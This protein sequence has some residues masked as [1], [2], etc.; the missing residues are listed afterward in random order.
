VYK[1]LVAFDDFLVDRTGYRVGF[2]Y[3]LIRADDDSQRLSLAVAWRHEWIDI[4]DIDD[5]A[6]P[7]AFLF[8][9]EQELRSVA[10]RLNH[11]LSDDIRNPE[12][13]W[14]ANIGYEYGGAALGGQLDFWKLSGGARYG[15]VLWR[16]R[17]GH[18][19]RFR[20]DAR[21]GLASKLDDTPEVPPY[22]RYYLGGNSFRGFANRGVGP[23]FGDS[24]TGGEWFFV[25]QSEFEVPVVRGTLAVVGFVDWGTL[26][27]SIDSDDAFRL[28]ASVGIGLRLV[29][30]II[31]NQPLAFDFGFPILSEDEDEK[32]VVSFSLGRDF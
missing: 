22:E 25:H 17:D 28:R 9:K 2:D 5:D 24:S 7:G 26:A 3:P 18:A 1:R 8:R 10:F 31:S 30:P 13:V 15:R 27:T 23:H 11:T 21:F 6:I 32:S 16:D 12:W 4:S 14:R 19:Y 20:T 29:V